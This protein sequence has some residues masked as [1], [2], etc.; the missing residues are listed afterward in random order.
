MSGTRRSSWSAFVLGACIVAAVAIGS[1]LANTAGATSAPVGSESGARHESA[2]F[3]S[4]E[5]AVSAYLEGMADGDLGTMVGAFAIETYAANYDLT[6]YLEWIGA[7]GPTAPVLLPASDPFNVALNTES[8][9]SRVV[10]SITFQYLTLSYPD[11][12]PMEVQPLA[13]DAAVDSFLEDLSANATSEGL[14]SIESF[15]FVPLEEVS[16]AAY[17]HYISDNN[18]QSMARRDSIVGADESTD[19]AVRFPTAGG[20]VYALFSLVRYADTWW[21]HDLGGTFATLIGLEFT[22]SGIVAVD[23]AGQ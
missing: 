11:F 9:Y 2:G 1:G 8:R 19:V 14:S 15:T 13:D 10:S 5:D 20:D 12:E 18:R 22:S 23:Q 7:Y 4:P 16:A 21:I 17:E 6:A 3:P